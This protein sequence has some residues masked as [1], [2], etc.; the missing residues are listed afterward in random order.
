[1]GQEQLSVDNIQVEMRN[2]VGVQ[3]TMSA[4]ACVQPM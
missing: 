2:G 3:S 4:G 1:M